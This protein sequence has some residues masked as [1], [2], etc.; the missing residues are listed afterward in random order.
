M[1]TF[2]KQTSHHAESK[3]CLLLLP[4]IYTGAGSI[5]VY[6]FCQSACRLPFQRRIDNLEQQSTDIW[7]L[8]FSYPKMYAFLP[9]F[10]RRSSVH[11]GVRKGK[12]KNDPGIGTWY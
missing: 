4:Q 11:L 5:R 3:Y 9:F 12:T 7:S 6:E 2:D 10:F 1:R 8:P